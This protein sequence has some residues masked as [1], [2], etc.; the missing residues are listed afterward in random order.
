MLLLTVSNDV[1]WV[2]AGIMIYDTQDREQ[3]AIKKC[4]RHCENPTILEG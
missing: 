2:V 1:L 4:A 3:D